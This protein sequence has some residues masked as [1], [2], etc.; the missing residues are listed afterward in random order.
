MQSWDD[1][2]MMV[3]SAYVRGIYVQG[4]QAYSILTRRWYTLFE[5]QQHG[6]EDE[7]PPPPGGFVPRP[8]WLNRG[9][10]PGRKNC[11]QLLRRSGNS[12]APLMKRPEEHALSPKRLNRQQANKFT[13]PRTPRELRW[14][15]TGFVFISLCSICWI[16]HA[17]STRE[18]L[19][20]CTT[21]SATYTSTGAEGIN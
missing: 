1:F 6:I 2:R 9:H 7:V 4:N 18:C 20:I 19:D 21:D 10:K 8:H 11:N 15:S 13:R 17:E 5:P 14:F 16:S 12:P 3:R